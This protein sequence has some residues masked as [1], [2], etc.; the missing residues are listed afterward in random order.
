MR[1]SLVGDEAGEVGRD[2][3]GRGHVDHFKDSG[4][5]PE[6]KGQPLWREC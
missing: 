4:L 6:N 2:G 3:P 5:Y 1:G